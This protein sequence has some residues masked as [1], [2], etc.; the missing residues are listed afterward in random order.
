MYQHPEGV[1]YNSLKLFINEPQHEVSTTERFFLCIWQRGVSGYLNSFLIQKSDLYFLPDDFD[2]NTFIPTTSNII[3][4]IKEII[5]KVNISTEGIT[6]IDI[7]HVLN[8]KTKKAIL[9]TMHNNNNNAST[10]NTR[11]SKEELIY[12]ISKYISSSLTKTRSFNEIVEFIKLPKFCLQTN[13][14]VFMYLNPNG[15]PSFIRKEMKNVLV[16]VDNFNYTLKC[17]AQL[18]L[19]QINHPTDNINDIKNIGLYSNSSVENNN[20]ISNA[21]SNQSNFSNID[22]KNYS[23]ET[24]PLYSRFSLLPTSAY[25][26]H[27]NSTKVINDIANIN[28]LPIPPI[29]NNNNKIIYPPGLL[30]PI[31]SPLSLE[32]NI[33]HSSPVNKEFNFTIDNPIIDQ[34]TAPINNNEALS[35]TTLSLSFL[36]DNK[37]TNYESN[38]NISQITSTLFYNNTSKSDCSLSDM[39]SPRFISPRDIM[40]SPRDQ[41]ITSWLPQIFYGYE[42]QQVASFIKSLQ[43][44]GGFVTVQDLIDAQTN[45][46]LT[47]DFLSKLNFKIGH[48]NRLY[49]GLKNSIV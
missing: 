2:I 23:Q 19:I 29:I 30:H 11:I 35:P 42:E 3:I 4:V 37:S 40:L 47:F 20:N 15:L 5:S 49:S 8:R 41:L 10:R 21:I 39:L 31:S 18:S 44:E 24:T 12:E 9:E 27:K 7:N 32:S 38:K 43:I 36:A 28:I 33:V 1:N 17:Y 26:N 34:S 6:I 45:N 14:D 22:K 16:P 46:Q 25:I 13:K 48:C